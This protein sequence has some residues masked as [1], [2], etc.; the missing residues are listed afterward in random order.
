M[1]GS[2]FPAIPRVKMKP[3]KPQNPNQRELF[4]YRPDGQI[5]MNHEL[6]RLAALID[7]SVFDDRFGALYHA[8]AGCPGNPLS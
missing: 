1:I 7:W 4:R 8:G 2:C 5:N 3:L 6:V